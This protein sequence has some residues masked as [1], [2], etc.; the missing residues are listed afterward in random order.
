MAT[1]QEDQSSIP[2]SSGRWPDAKVESN[3]IRRGPHAEDPDASL[4]QDLKL[5]LPEAYN[6]LFNAYAKRLMR[7]AFKITMCTEDAEDAVQNT[8]LQVF[9]NIERFRGE[10]QFGSWITAIAINQGLMTLRR[11]KRAT[12]SLDA[13]I[14]AG[15]HHI[16]HQITGRECTPEQACLRRELEESLIGFVTKLRKTN[17]SVFEMHFA[18]ELSLDEIAQQ[19]GIT[20]AATKSRL[21]RAQRD[22]RSRA[23]K[24]SQ[25]MRSKKNLRAEFSETE[26]YV[27]N[28]E[29]SDRADTT[30]PV[31]WQSIAS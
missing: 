30:M 10:C 20:R 27:V 24:H 21:F 14:E 25:P 7:V 17:R 28:S 22:I 13:A 15:E 5:R 4:I 16:F 19:L 3:C 23:K 12:V 26:G 9:R 2:N 1:R 6:L 31:D 11:K 8:F 18:Q 29:L